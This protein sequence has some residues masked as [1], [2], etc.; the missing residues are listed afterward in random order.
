MCACVYVCVLAHVCVCVRVCSGKENNQH[1][2]LTLIIMPTFLDSGQSFYN[3]FYFFIFFN[4]NQNHKDL[5]KHG[6]IF[7]VTMI[8]I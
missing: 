1:N 6:C 2:G 3:F 7:L 4:R 5:N 8:A